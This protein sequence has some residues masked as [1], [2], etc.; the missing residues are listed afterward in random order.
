M[1]QTMFKDWLL[2]R[3][4]T[5]MSEYLMDAA[6]QTYIGQSRYSAMQ[7]KRYDIPDAFWKTFK[8]A[9]P[10]FEKLFQDDFFRKTQ[11]NW[12]IIGKLLYWD[13]ETLGYKF[14]GWPFR[15]KGYGREIIRKD[16]AKGGGGR[17]GPQPPGPPKPPS[18]PK[19]PKY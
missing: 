11:K 17:R 2:E 6:A 3:D 5:K 16:K 10:V 7:F 4:N 15:K 8:P 12:P 14:S 19:P 9:T 1:G 13:K 18:P